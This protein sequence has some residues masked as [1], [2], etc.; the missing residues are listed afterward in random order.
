[1]FVRFY[2]SCVV[3]FVL[4][5]VNNLGM[6][7][8]LNV[9]EGHFLANDGYQNQVGANDDRYNFAN[10]DRYNFM[11]C[12]G[13][14]ITDTLFCVG[15]CISNILFCVDNCVTNSLFCVDNC[16]KNT[17]LCACDCI[18]KS[19]WGSIR[20]LNGKVLSLG[21]LFYC[22]CYSYYGLYCYGKNGM[23][24]TARPVHGRRKGVYDIINRNR[25]FVNDS[26]NGDDFG[27]IYDNCD[28][29]YG[30]FEYELNKLTTFKKGINYFFDYPL[31]Y[32]DKAIF[33][34]Y[35]DD[36]VVTVNNPI[37]C[38]ENSVDN[39]RSIFSVFNYIPYLKLEYNNFSDIR[40]MFSNLNV[41]YLNIS[42]LR[43][44]NI[45]YIGGLFENSKIMYFLGYEYKTFHNIIIFDRVFKNAT[46]EGTLDLSNWNISICSANEAFKNARIM[47]IKLN[48]F[49]TIF[50]N[51]M[52]ESFYSEYIK[53]LYLDSWDTTFTSYCGNVFHKNLRSVQFDVEKNQI[54]VDQLSNN[55]DFDFLCIKNYCFS[56]DGGK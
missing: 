46:I 32:K 31:D 40:Y 18:K 47:K 33:K 4:S 23:S 43:T 34:F 28:E 16:V 29:I 12:V 36:C 42:N 20:F 51:F 13:N 45:E 7:D 37:I 41:E 55:D 52:I 10:D 1:M 24:N 50:L 56:V 35:K 3:L 21:F 19:F 39:C 30:K 54:L 15:N 2:I 5:F 11:H 53:Y 9:E 8:A 49:N 27:Y 38:E 25:S 44:E 17:F 6:H 22:C 14:C 26:Y 48:N